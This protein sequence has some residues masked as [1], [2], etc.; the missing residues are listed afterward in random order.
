MVSDQFTSAHRV[1]IAIQDTAMERKWT[2]TTRMTRATVIF[3]WFT[4][5]IQRVMC[6]GSPVCRRAMQWHRSRLR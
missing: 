6:L 4:T 5:R 2:H 1:C 3:L